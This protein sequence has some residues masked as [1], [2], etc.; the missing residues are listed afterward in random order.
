MKYSSDK[1]LQDFIIV[2][3]CVI[4]RS[5]W[6]GVFLQ[7]IEWELILNEMIIIKVLFRKAAKFSSA[8]L[9]ESILN[10]K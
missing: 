8:N 7:V 2:A 10:L 1:Q 5:Y 4:Y 9:L 3:F 6:L